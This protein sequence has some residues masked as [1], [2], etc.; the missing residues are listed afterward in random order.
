[1]RVKIGN[2][3]HD[4]NEEPICIQLSPGEQEQ[5]AGMDRTKAPEGK[6]AIFPGSW[7]GDRCAMRRWMTDV[8]EPDAIREQLGT[9][10]AELEEE[11]EHTR[12]QRDAA[13]RRAQ[14]AEGRCPDGY[15]CRYSLKG[16]TCGDPL[17]RER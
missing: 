3:W 1:M 11:L 15:Y 17:C 5:V 16:E 8:E 14:I 7:G 4:S 13:I 2:Q 9:R 12:G 6:F 10:I